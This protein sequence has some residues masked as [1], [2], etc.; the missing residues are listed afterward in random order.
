M[1]TLV[2]EMRRR[3]PEAD[4]PFYGLAAL[5]VGVGMG[6]ATVIEWID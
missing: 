1:T 6:E 5:C 4:R 2:H 3:A